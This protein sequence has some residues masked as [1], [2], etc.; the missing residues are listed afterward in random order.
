M[1]AQSPMTTGEKIVKCRERFTTFCKHADEK[2]EGNFKRMEDYAR[3][4]SLSNVMFCKQ[5]AE[6]I[7]NLKVEIEHQRELMYAKIDAMEGNI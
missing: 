1:T 3:G 7:E 5:Y 2:I 4:R 6:N